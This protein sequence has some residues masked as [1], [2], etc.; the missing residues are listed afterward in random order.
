MSNH[1]LVITAYDPAWPGAFAVEAARITAAC[2]VDAAVEHIGST[3][4]PGL[5]AKPVLDVLVG[6]GALDPDGAACVRALV[7]D[8]Y[9][10]RPDFEE[11]MPDRRYF[12]RST[13]DGVRI[14]N[15]HLVR[16]GGPMW[17]QTLA[18]RDALREDPALRAG[19]EAAKRAALATAPED[20]HRYN[21]AK[22]PFIARTLEAL[23]VAP[24]GPGS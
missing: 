9:R 19:Y 16:R 12:T 13:A 18:F 23:G 15:V 20:V 14:A 8:G 22:A 24:P 1:P 3:A 4:V 6:V 7:A 10:H 17:R 2:P 11:A 5:A 21:D